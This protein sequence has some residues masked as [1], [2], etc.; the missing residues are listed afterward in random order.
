M[1]K[2]FMIYRNKKSSYKELFFV[3]KYLLEIKYPKT[4]AAKNI[5][6]I[7]PS[8]GKP[9]GGVGGGGVSVISD[10]IDN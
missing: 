5:T 6:T 2:R 4:K 1:L 10:A 8:I 7:P 3:N 9:G